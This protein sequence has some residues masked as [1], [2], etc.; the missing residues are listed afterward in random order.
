MKFLRMRA[1]IVV[2]FRRNIFGVWI[3][4]FPGT[5]YSIRSTYVLVSLIG[6]RP[7]QLPAWPAP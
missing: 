4:K 7:G 1:E 3:L 5:I 2:Y 6:W